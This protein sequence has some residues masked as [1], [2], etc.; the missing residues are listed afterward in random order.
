MRSIYMPEDEETA[1]KIK[2]CRASDKA[3]SPSLAA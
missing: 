2:A 3:V 1:N